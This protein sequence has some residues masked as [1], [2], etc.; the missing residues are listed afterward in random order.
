LRQCLS[1]SRNQA[2]TCSSSA[3]ALA[4]LACVFTLFLAGCGASLS[5]G[6]Q[7][8]GLVAKPGSITFG[9]LP[10]GSSATAEVTL[11]N[12]SLQ[13]V[14][15]LSVRTS[16]PAFSVL[17][18]VNTPVNVP[19][20]G[21]Y[22]LT[23]TFTPQQAGAATG[24]LTISTLATSAGRAVVQLSGQATGT[25]APPANATLAVS[26]GSLS[27]GSVPLNSAA[28]QTLTLKSTGS[29][30]RQATCAHGPQ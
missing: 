12:E 24:S 29:A 6:K 16:N 14:E 18:P 4:A 2:A 13:A 1:F 21:A 10:V 25:S 23:V 7:A 3:C 11:V 17:N 26:S 8:G 15:I 22:H 5:I 27:F 30:P 19:G 28:T 20:G 9:S